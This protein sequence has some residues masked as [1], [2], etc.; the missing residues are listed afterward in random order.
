[1]L[2]AMRVRVWRRVGPRRRLLLEA[3]PGLLLAVSTISMVS[4][5]AMQHSWGSNDGVVAGATNEANEA[6]LQAQ[7]QAEAAKNNA[8]KK[9]SANSGGGSDP[10]SFVLGSD[11]ASA[12]QTVFTNRKMWFISTPTSDSTARELAQDAAAKLR[13][14]AATGAESLV[15]MEPTVL[16]GGTVNFSTYQSGGY[17]SYLATFYNEIKKLGITDQLMG[18]WTLLPE[19]NMPEWGN[20]D[21]S[22][23]SNCIIHTAK[24]QKTVFPDSLISLMLNAKTYPGNDTAYANGQ[25]KSLLPYVQSIPKGLVDSFGYQGFPWL[26]PANQPWPSDTDPSNY[27]RANL[28]IEAAQSLGVHSVWF[29][30][31][32]QKRAYT[33]S[34]GQAATLSAAQRGQILHGA[35]GQAQAVRAAG[36][37][38]AVNIFAGDKSASS[39]AIDWS[40]PIGTDKQVLDSF[41]GDLQANGMSFWQYVGG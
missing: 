14:V 33:N 5:K 34:P 4:V 30:T 39:E 28:A 25:Y 12:S 7:K 26:A 36:Y 29:N 19:G 1:M 38:V 9:S 3:V 27:L 24:I 37:G 2:F 6:S 10:L 40:Y 18:M 21:P 17:D 20:S 41:V 13:Q 15:I 31:G 22:T 35:L 11:P 23:I 8:Q 32:T 16:G